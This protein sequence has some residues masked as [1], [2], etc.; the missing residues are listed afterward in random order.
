MQNYNQLLLSNKAWAKEKVYDDPEFFSR[1]T[2]VQTPQ[3]LWIG[4]SDSRVPANQITDTQP[5]EIFVHRNVANLVV[6]ADVNLLAVLDYAVNHLKVKHIIVCGHYGC[7]G[8]KASM[9]QTDLS[10]M[11]NVWLRNI[12]DVYRMHR[13][14]LDGIS[15]MDKR[16]DRLVE[17]NV[18]EQVFNLAKTAII[19]RAWKE[20]EAPHLHGW[21]Y[22]L[23]DGLIN[24][25]FE[26][27]AGTR[28]DHIYEYD[29][30]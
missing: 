18:Q 15:D 20:R 28:I 6:N 8:V 5:G 10:A 3:F 25:V 1:L 2:N 24:P 30:L 11:L 23:K 12:K 27:P 19:Q 29:N 13:T 26:M 22:G 9:T 7:G 21:V 14:E 4:C 17:L 16:T